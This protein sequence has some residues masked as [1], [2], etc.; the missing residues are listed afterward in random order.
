[1][2]KIGKKFK[3]QQCQSLTAKEILED[4]QRQASYQDP[5]FNQAVK[6]KPKLG[7]GREIKKRHEDRIKEENDLMNRDFDENDPDAV[8][9]D[10]DDAKKM[11]ARERSKRLENIDEQATSVQKSQEPDYSGLLKKIRE[12]DEHNIKL[13]EGLLDEIVPK[14]E[15]K[16]NKSTPRTQNLIDFID[17]KEVPPKDEART[18]N[19]N[20]ILGNIRNDNGDVV[21]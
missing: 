19:E 11:L 5:T 3:D 12:E 6:I 16:A 18:F 21:I 9:I 13:E 15:L 20:D 8:Q 4:R 7:R 1:M 2:S 10:E 14:E 17:G